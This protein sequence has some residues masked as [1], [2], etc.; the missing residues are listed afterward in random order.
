MTPLLRHF[1]CFNRDAVGAVSCASA[2]SVVIDGFI[3][4]RGT[5]DSGENNDPVPFGA[6]IWAPIR[7]SEAS[8]SE[9][10]RA[11]Q[12]IDTQMRAMSI[13]VGQLTYHFTNMRSRVLA[14]EARTQA[15]ENDI[16]AILEEPPP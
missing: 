11:L 7:I 9:L 6:G 12:Q 15:A 3:V 2:G 8:L 10:R 4:K 14:N 16:Q 5:Y 13:V 1:F